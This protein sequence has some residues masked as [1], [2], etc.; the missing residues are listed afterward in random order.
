MLEDLSSKLESFIKSIK[1]Q[2]HF[3]QKNIEDISQ[4]LRM[5]LLEA[6]VHYKVAKE[7]VEKVTQNALGQRIH[8]SLTPA[9]HYISRP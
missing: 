7:F 5:T 3:T 6:D 8:E 1:G 9:Q 4:K 2:G